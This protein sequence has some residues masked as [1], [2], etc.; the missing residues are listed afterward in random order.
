MGIESLPILFS[1][2]RCPYA[3]RGRLALASAQIKC[4]LREVILRDKPQALLE[5]SPKGTVPVL[6][7]PDGTV[8]DESL[9][10]MLW[11][12]KQRDPESWLTPEQGSRDQMLALIAEND[13][14]FKNHLDRYKYPV[15]YDLD[16]GLGDRDAAASWLQALDQRLATSA[17]LFGN[18]P[19]L[20]DMAIAPFVRQYA[21]TDRNWFRAQDWP[22]LCRWLDAFLDSPLFQRIMQKHVRWTPDQT[23][24]VFP[25]ENDESGHSGNDA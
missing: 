18:R 6:V 10:I 9:D 21:H 3:M 17:Y 5:A 20:A 22:A 19:A 1:F 14:P 25:S 12:L 13:G 16:S 23:P 15:R 2:R 4:Q 8:I 7:L 24:V 11:A